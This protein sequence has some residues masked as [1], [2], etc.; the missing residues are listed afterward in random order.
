MFADKWGIDSLKT[1]TL[2]KLHGT[3]KTFT[4]YEARCSDIVELLRYT[5]STTHTPDLVDGVDGLRSLVMLYT[6][7]EVEHC[8][9]VLLLIGDSGQLAQDLVKVLMQRIS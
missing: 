7:C 3:L 2:F 6:A 9:E 4:L 5:F 8:P 1:L